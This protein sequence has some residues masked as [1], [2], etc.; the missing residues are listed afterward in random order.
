[1]SGVPVLVSSIVT[2]NDN[3]NGKVESVNEI[4]KKTCESRN[5]GFIDHNNI[6]NVNLNGSN[7]HLNQDGNVKFTKNFVSA[8]KKH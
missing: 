3:L 2:R 6:C 8:V 4:L 5:I 1:M 7:V